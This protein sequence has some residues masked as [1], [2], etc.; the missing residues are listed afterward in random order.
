MKSQMQEIIH[1]ISGYNGLGEQGARND[2]YYEDQFGNP[3]TWQEKEQII[4]D[5]AESH[6]EYSDIVKIREFLD[7]DFNGSQDDAYRAWKF[8]GD[9]K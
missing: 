6:I 3:Q 9:E 1:S 4:N 7:A 2:W 5:I 8:L